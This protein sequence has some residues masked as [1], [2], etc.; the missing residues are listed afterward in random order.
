MNETEATDWRTTI[1]DLKT[2]ATAFRNAT[3]LID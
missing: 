1:E 2:T 3:N